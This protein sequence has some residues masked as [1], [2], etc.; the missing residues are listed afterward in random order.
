[1]YYVYFKQNIFFKY[2]QTILM[3]HYDKQKL[4]LL[5]KGF[6]TCIVCLIQMRFNSL[7]NLSGNVQC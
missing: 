1:M 4:S 7:L 3:S 6:I 5:F 2:N